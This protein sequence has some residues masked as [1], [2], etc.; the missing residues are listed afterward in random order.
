VSVP[1]PSLVRLAPLV[2]DCVFDSTPLMVRSTPLVKIVAAP[3]VGR[4]VKSR[5]VEVKRGPGW[6]APELPTPPVRTRL[7]GSPSAPALATTV[8]QLRSTTSP[9]KLVAAFVRAVMPA[10]FTIN[11]PVPV[12]G[13]E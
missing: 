7:A 2:Y 1:R 10:V 8:V 11:P 4:R 9:G 3:L 12:I 6:R 5:V 13:P